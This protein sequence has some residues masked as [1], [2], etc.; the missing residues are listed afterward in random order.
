MTIFVFGSGTNHNFENAPN[1]NDLEFT[2][3]PDKWVPQDQLEFHPAPHNPVVGNNPFV[4]DN[5]GQAEYRFDENGKRIGE[6]PLANLP[7]ARIGNSVSVGN[8]PAPPPETLLHLDGFNPEE[9]S[10]SPLPQDPVPGP[11]ENYLGARPPTSLP[12][13]GIEGSDWEEPG[14]RPLHGWPTDDLR[15]TG[16][17]SDDASGSLASRYTGIDDTTITGRV[18]QAPGDANAG[19]NLTVRTNLEVGDVSGHVQIAHNDPNQRGASQTL[20]GG[21]EIPL[22]N[23]TLGITANTNFGA[24]T[25]NTGVTYRGNVDDNTTFSIGVN[26]SDPT[27]FG[28]NPTVTGE[29]TINDDGSR[30][31]GARLFGS[32]NNDRGLQGGFRVLFGR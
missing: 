8:V 10:T 22:G 7:G 32:F 9:Y 28:G 31:W 20:S 17:T 3:D 25:I 15:L 19:Y 26:N 27:A 4:A 5:P 24:D 12:G 16:N 30:G 18:S 23:G 11:N 29:L 21:V 1:A 14:H 6:N 2:T 13:D